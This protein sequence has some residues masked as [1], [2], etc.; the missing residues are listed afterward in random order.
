[1]NDAA[2]HWITTFEWHALLDK[3]GGDEVFVSGLVAVALRSNVAMPADLR[4][5][6]DAGDFDRMMR[7]AH[8]IKGTAGDLCAP[9]LREQAG[10][11][12]LAARDASGAAAALT[13]G[14]ADA[15]DA[16]LGDLRR[17][18]ATKS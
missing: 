13:R 4:A 12:E 16:L 17:I 11:A 15:V 5:A 3:L 6:A 1:M 7:L 18:A 9:A 10:R 2:P 14:L 8:K